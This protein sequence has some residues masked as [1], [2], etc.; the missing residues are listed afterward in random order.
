MFKK[1]LAVVLPAVMI[2]GLLAGCAP[3]DS[4][5]SGNGDGG[6]NDGSSNSGSKI[7]VVSREEGSGTRTAFVELLGVEE[8]DDAGNKTDKTTADAL[9]ANKTD[10]MITQVMGNKNA[11]GYI[12]LG[13]LSDKVKALKL[14]GVEATGENI[15]NGTYKAARPFNIVTK[16]TAE[17]L[18]KDFLDFIMSEEGQKVVS[19]N[20]YIAVNDSATPYAGTKPEG[21]ITIAGSSSVTPVMEKLVEAYNAINPAAVIEVQQSDSSAGVKAAQEG[22]AQIGMVSRELKD[23]EKDLTATVIAQDGIAIIVNTEN[24]LDDISSEDVAAIYKGE[25]TT[26]DK[27]GK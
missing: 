26:W 5:G 7:T 10:V 23:S 11:I 8:K 22:T 25:T 13:S 15:K 27:V 14:D 21:R 4:Y 6:S 2:C 1:I 3:S 20:G 12:S 24:A 9:I 18:T 17:G 16:G 19:D